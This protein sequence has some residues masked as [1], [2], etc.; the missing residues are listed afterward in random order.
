MA[1]IAVVALAVGLLGDDGPRT[2]EER[3][4]ALSESVRCPTCR[5]QSVAESEAPIAR[6]IRAEI[7]NRIESG[8]SD[9]EIRD[10]LVSRYGQ[11]ILL[12]P[13]ASG[14]AGLVWVIPVVAVVIAGVGLW[15]AFRR[16]REQP[17]VHASEADRELVEAALHHDRGESPGS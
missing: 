7:G 17:T 16:W 11:V 9:D 10:Y 1:L 6:E 4:T 2:T 13:P 5:S 3:V 14:V 8:E 15:L 12:T